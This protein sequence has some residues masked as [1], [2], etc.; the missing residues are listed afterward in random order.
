MASKI[1]T[2]RD[3]LIQNRAAKNARLDAIER[4]ELGKKISHWQN[5]VVKFGGEMQRQTLAKFEA[6]LAAIG[7]AP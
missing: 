7:G 2:V 1:H 4:R 3:A 6:Q 5:Q